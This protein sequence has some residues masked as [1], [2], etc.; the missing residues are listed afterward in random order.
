MHCMIDVRRLR[1]LRELADHGTIAAAAAAL[2]LTPSAV[3]QQLAA[4]TRE[5]GV[6]LVEPDGRRVRLTD[7]AQVLLGHA[8][9]VFAQLEQAEVDLARHAEG[10]VTTVRVGAFPSALAG[11]VS[12][13]TRALRDEQPPVTVQAVEADE[14]T[15]FAQL[16]A[17]DLDVAVSVELSGAPQQDGPRFHRQPLLTDVLDAAL[18][19]D[20]PL[21]GKRA[22]ELTDLA[23]ADWVIGNPGSSCHDVV[24][25]ACATV[26]FTPRAVHHTSDWAAVASL[27]RDSDAVA[28]MPRLAQSLVPNGIVVV[29]LHGST[30]ARH[31]FA[32]TRRGNETAPTTRRTLQ[33]LTEAANALG[34]LSPASL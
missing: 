2:H 33:H 22:I 13:V 7:A 8:H 19:V 14:R 34:G 9:L 30:A 28:L 26:G 1:V 17:G 32:A 29:P 11:L 31:V 12:P 20:H 5:T 25:V 6:Q 4:L 24:V 15:C 21:A 27:V 16:A 23:G 18:P 3:S 10:H